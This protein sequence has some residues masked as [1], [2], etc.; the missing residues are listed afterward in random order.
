MRPTP[1]RLRPWFLLLALAAAACAPADTPIKPVPPSADFR[2]ATIQVRIAPDH[3]DWTYRL[4][5]PVKFRIVVTADNTPLD[6]VTVTYSVGPELMPVEKRTATVPLDGLVVEGGT[7]HT[8]GFIRCK[9]ATEFAGRTYEGAATAA[10]APE[11]IKPFQTEPADFEAFWQQ[12]KANLALIPVEAKVT[13]LPDACTDTVNVYHVGIRTVGRS[14]SGAGRVYG[15][16]TEPKAPGRYPAVL[17]V[18]GAGVR[19][20]TGNTDWAARGAIVLEIGIHGIPVNLAPEVY[21]QLHA[22]PLNGYQT[23]NLD[24]RE[25]YFYRRVYLNCLRANDFLTSRPMWNGH[26]LLVT[27]ASQG[28]LLSIVTAALDPRVTALAAIH[29]AMCD[30]VAPLHGRAGGWPHP[31]K[32]SDNGSPSPHATPAKIATSAY[33]DAVNFARRLKV[34]GFYIW[35]FNDE[36]TPPTSTFAAYNVITSPKTLAVQPEQGHTYPIE[37]WEAVSRW[38]STTLKFK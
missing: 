30:L 21:D 35:G 6:N 26:D 25:T 36:V 17:M 3:R 33:Y 16:L 22:G 28:G 2:V 20:Y 11:T 15:I 34:P 1:F 31:F 32:P 18:P 7:L 14:W 5:E 9:A 29:P 38:V 13:L 8:G 10:I 27:G 37:Q 4:G 24:D 23:F 12:G 19:P